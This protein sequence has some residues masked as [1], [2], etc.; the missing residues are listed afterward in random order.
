MMSTHTWTHSSQIDA[1]EPAI[2]LRT[3]WW[4]FAQKEQWSAGSDSPR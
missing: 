3:S 4:V 2:N 1:D